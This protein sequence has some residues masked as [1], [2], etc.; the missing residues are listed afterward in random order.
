MRVK[1]ALLITSLFVFRLVYGLFSDFWSEDELQVY[2]IGL[3]SFTTHTWP[4]YGADVVYTNTQ[5]AGALQ[6]LLISIPFSIIKQPESPVVFLNILSFASLSFLAVYI[7]RRIKGVPVWIVWVI[8]M[9]TPWTMHFSTRVVNPSYALVFAI[10]FFS[11]V[12][13]L[14]PI[15]KKAILPPKLAFFIL[16]IC[17]TLIMQLH[18][19]WV[20]LVPFVGVIFLL[21][22]KTKI[23]QQA[24]NVGVFTL[25]LFI[26]ALTLVPTLLLDQTEQTTAN[27]VFNGGNWSNLPIII[28]RF[29]SFAS[30][31][32][33]YMLGA[34][35][36]ERLA[37]I[38]NQIWMSPVAAFLLVIG[39]AQ[40]GIFIL[41]L[42]NK[43]ISDEFKKVKWLIL[44]SL[45]LLYVS[46]FFSIK[47]PSPHTFYIML[48]LA[49]FYA[50]YCY[51]WLI[52][53]SKFALRLLK[54]IALCGI[55]FHIGLGAYKFQYKSMYQNRELVV[56]ALHEMDYKVLGKRRTR[57]LGTWVLDQIL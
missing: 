23:T 48:P 56:K 2:L 1:L 3:K 54:T 28:M 42:F 41:F 13:D 30:T 21:K 25:G 47:G 55:V 17:L 11:C 39:F 52:A 6:G 53:K 12:L 46:F 15:Y 38:Y 14:L 32:L 51:E 40:V 9:T 34:N 10:P 24:V 35:T 8:V 7:T 50:F 4:Y 33:P 27:I 45:L 49:L 31:E 57:P 20:L 22:I 19:S 36:T 26:G 43:N 37:V 5:V 18:L 44:G 16:G 29:F